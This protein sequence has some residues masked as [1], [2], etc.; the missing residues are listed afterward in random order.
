MNFFLRYFK[1]FVFKKKWRA[2]NLNNSTTP[3]NLFP[4]NLVN[5]GKYSYGPLNVFTW[6]DANEK[7]EIG[8]FVSISS[9]VKFLLGGNHEINNFSTFPFKVMILKEKQEAWTKGAIVV[10]DDVWIGMDAM[11]LSGVKIGKGAII[12]ANSVVT[13]D[14]LP[15]SVVAG[16]PA[17]HLKF[18]F[19]KDILEELENIDIS[20]LDEKFVEEN[21]ELLYRKCDL[22]VIQEIKSA[23]KK[24]DNI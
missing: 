23:L 6:G 10:E 20:L 3:Q 12:A 18:R 11:I 13:K 4:R 15:Y 9:G 24:N 14:I 19:N 2:D 21:I 1:L 5:V 17:K 8:S 16:N 22:E 7:L